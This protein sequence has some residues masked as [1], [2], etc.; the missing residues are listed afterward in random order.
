MHTHI[1]THAYTC[2]RTCTHILS[3]FLSLSLSLS[4]SIYLSIYIYI[5]I[6]IYISHHYYRDSVSYATFSVRVKCA[7]TSKCAGV[8]KQDTLSLDFVRNTASRCAHT[9]TRPHTHPQPQKYP[10]LVMCESTVHVVVLARE[11]VVKHVAPEAAG[12]C[13][14]RMRISCEGAVHSRMHTHACAICTCSANLC[15]HH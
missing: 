12:F 6:Y 8:W 11:R 4:L 1:N 3:L 13:H 14:L 9:L 10:H 7:N 5:Y 2:T 15:A